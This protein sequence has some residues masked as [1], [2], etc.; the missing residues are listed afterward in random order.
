MNLSPMRFKNYVWPH[1]PRIYEIEFKRKMISHHVPF[2]R[3]VLESMGMD[4]RVLRGEG[5]F[6]GTGAYREFQKLASVFYEESPGIL[7]HPVWQSANAW[8]VKL[9]VQQEPLEN[10]VRY[11]FE[12]WECYDGY[13]R[14]LREAERDSGGL[15]K[16]AKAQP[17]ERYYTVV[18]GDTM[19]AIAQK[20]GMEL[21]KL[22]ALNPQ[23]RNINLI[24]PRDRLRVE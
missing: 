3:S 17:V 19:Y 5:E 21:P 12:F 22:V 13:R 20:Y 11:S 16:E 18:A 24:Y 15:Q 7:V 6:V 9:A 2:G 14:T 8:F 10:Y 23:V 4:Y 1:N